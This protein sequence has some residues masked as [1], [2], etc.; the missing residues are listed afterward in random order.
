MCY[1]PVE[2]ALKN[3]RTKLVAVKVKGHRFFSRKMYAFYPN[4]EFLTETT[5]DLIQF[6]KSKYTD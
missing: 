2:M 1:V 6:I 5:K 3:K 4:E